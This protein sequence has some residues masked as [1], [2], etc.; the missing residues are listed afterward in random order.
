MHCKQCARFLKNLEIWEAR[1]LLLQHLWRRDK[2]ERGRR[3]DRVVQEEHVG[4]NLVF[5]LAVVLVLI[6]V[7]VLVL[8]L[9][10]RSCSFHHARAHARARAHVHSIMLV[11]V[12]P[13]RIVGRSP[14]YGRR[15]GWSAE[16][17]KTSPASRDA[18][19]AQSGIQVLDL[20][21]ISDAAEAGPEV[22][23]REG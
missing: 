7:V 2:A 6:L 9:V 12:H 14:S 19:P 11:L 23:C 5:A 21:I 10:T 4:S 17:K 18:G 3:P 22:R 1:A 15:A 13:V 16:S 20:G 8:V